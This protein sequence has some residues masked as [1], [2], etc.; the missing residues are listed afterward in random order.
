MFKY[1]VPGIIQLKYKNC[2]E[3]ITLILYFPIKCEKG[4]SYPFNNIL[5]KRGNN[6]FSSVLE[7]YKNP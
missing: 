3:K 4:N 7:K 5:F 1:R 2:I 6:E